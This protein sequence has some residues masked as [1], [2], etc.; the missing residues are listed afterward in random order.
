M[1]DRTTSAGLEA[2]VLEFAELLA[3][4]RPLEAMQRFYADEINVFENRELARAGKAR[5]LELE[6]AA[7]SSQP[8][9]PRFKLVKLA[10]NEK[11]GHAFLEYRVRFQSKEGRPMCL[12][13]VAV[14]TWEAGQIV[15]ERFY[16]EGVVD[17]GDADGD[18]ED[19]A[20]PTSGVDYLVF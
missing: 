10:V 1:T 4:G 5:C 11:S 16:Y 8:G 3:Q 17:E 7:L 19:D 12:E 18:T 13:E 15:E 6:R 14:Q 20:A 2:S 9:P